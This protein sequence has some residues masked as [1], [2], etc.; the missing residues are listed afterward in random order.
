M[1]KGS[2]PVLLGTAALAWFGPLHE[3]IVS[4]SASE[5]LGLEILWQGREEPL[6]QTGSP[7]HEGDQRGTGGRSAVLEDQRV[8]IGARRLTPSQGS[9]C[10]CCWCSNT[11]PHRAAPPGVT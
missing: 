7:D 5:H 8:T 4:S 2:N 1:L 6:G 11:L 3:V 9:L 10:L